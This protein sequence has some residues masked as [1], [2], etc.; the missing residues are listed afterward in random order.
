MSIID[1]LKGKDKDNGNSVNAKAQIQTTSDDSAS[2]EKN[3]ANPSREVLVKSKTL[4]I[5]K[6]VVVFK[7]IKP[8]HGPTREQFNIYQFNID[9][10]CKMLERDAILFW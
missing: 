9:G 7:K 5:E 1:K 8:Q 6:I 3:E 4:G 10:E 2:E